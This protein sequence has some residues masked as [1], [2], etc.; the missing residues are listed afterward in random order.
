LNL[1][2]FFP[3]DLQ[4]LQGLEHG[5]ARTAERLAHLGKVDVWVRRDVRPELF[6]VQLPE[7]VPARHVL[8]APRPQ[9][10]LLPFVDGERAD[11]ERFLRLAHAVPLL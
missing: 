1:L 11:A 2:V 5:R 4:P 7:R 3:R 10:L 9:Q 6:G 8:Q